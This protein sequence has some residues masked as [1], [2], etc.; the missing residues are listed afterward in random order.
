MGPGQ[1]KEDGK[2]SWVNMISRQH[3]YQEEKLKRIKGWEAGS[4]AKVLP[5]EFD[6]QPRTHIN[7]A[8]VVVQRKI[9]DIH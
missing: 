9:L 4:V 5:P 6:Y 1:E 2:W 8:G 3:I 7:K